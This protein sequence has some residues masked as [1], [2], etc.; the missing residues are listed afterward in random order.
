MK[1][2]RYAALLTHRFV[3]LQLTKFLQS[4]MIA[5]SFLPT[6]SHPWGFLARLFQNRRVYHITKWPTLED[7]VD[8]QYSAKSL[9]LNARGKWCSGFAFLHALAQLTSTAQR[10]PS[11]A[12]PHCKPHQTRL[13]HSSVQA[14]YTLHSRCPCGYPLV[15]RDACQRCGVKNWLRRWWGWR[16]MS[17]CSQDR[18]G[19][20]NR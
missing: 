11:P 2:W 10:H 7:E 12:V 8:P 1:P 17:A 4:I 5:E 9:V 3:A 6:P 18:L 19:F 16:F 20:W 15:P 13:P 14:L